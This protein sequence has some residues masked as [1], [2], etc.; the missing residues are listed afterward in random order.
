[1]RGGEIRV[2]MIARGGRVAPLLDYLRYLT[3][4][5][6]LLVDLTRTRRGDHPDP[7]FF[8]TVHRITLVGSR[9]G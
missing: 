8:P 5:T 2:R 3:T 7:G 6:G 1:M 9:G 4:G